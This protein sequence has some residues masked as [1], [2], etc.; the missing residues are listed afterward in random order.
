M[1]KNIIAEVDGRVDWKSVFDYKTKGLM[2][3]IG[4]RAGVG[5]M[6]GI[7]VHG[8]LAWCIWRNYYLANLPTLHKKI[9]VLADWIIYLFFRRDVTM[10]KT[11]AEN[12]DFAKSPTNDSLMIQAM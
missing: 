2:A 4:T 9:R 1:A 6:F 5:N 11:F 10:L 8:F 3:S 12:R 7:Q